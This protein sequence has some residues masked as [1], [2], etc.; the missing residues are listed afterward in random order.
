MKKYPVDL[1]L[2]S[3]ASFRLFRGQI[4]S[5]LWYAC[6]FGEESQ[7]SRLVL[8]CRCSMQID[9]P[10]VRHEPNLFRVFPAL[11]KHV[12]VGW[13]RVSV[14]F[15]ADDEHRALDVLDVIDGTQLPG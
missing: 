5:F 8:L 12:C 9:V 2:K 6:R 15:A 1:R 14:V 4:L 13:S 3:F 11:N 7:D 10:S